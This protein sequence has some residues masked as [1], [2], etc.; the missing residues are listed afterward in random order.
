ME[1]RE[2]LFLRVFESFIQL[3]PVFRY[4][5]AVVHVLKR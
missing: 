4:H 5:K 2:R 3:N 1:E